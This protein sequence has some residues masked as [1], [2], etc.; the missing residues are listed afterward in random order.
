[1]K[2]SLLVSA[3]CALVATPVLASPKFYGKA[4][5][6][7]QAADE[8][9]DTF[10]EVTSNA[11]RLGIKG[12]EVVKDSGLEVIYQAEFEV[13]FDGDNGGDTFSQRNIFIGLKTDYGT[14]KAG[15]FDTPLKEIQNKVDLFNDLEG[16]IKKML[17]PNETRANDIV[18]YSS[19]RLAGLAATLA[20]VPSESKASSAE[21]ELDDGFSSSLSFTKSNVYLALAYDRNIGRA[22]SAAL[23]DEDTLRVVGQ[24]TIGGF[25]IGALYEIMDVEGRDS[26]EDAVLASLQYSW[27]K[28]AL[29]A[30]HGVSD[31][32]RTNGR[33]SSIGADYAFD[34][35]LKA[36]TY[37]TLIESDVTLDNEY[38]GLGLEYKF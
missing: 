33:N 10:A 31:L 19:P 11:S 36:F 34:K 25:Q 2:K 30:Q 35:S 7:V 38:L 15:K 24:F 12:S 21:V 16:D 26:N 32:S 8:G 13:F 4:N 27:D 29:K 3:I 28:L 5:V 18:S 20:Y 1:M 22:S 37:Y 23:L 9:K 17:T 14:L 6:S